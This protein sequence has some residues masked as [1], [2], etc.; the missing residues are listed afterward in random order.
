MSATGFDVFDKTL[1]TTNIWLDE[2]SATIGPDRQLA[3]KI[4]SVVLHKLR[5]RLPVFRLGLRR[6]LQH[7]ADVSELSYAKEALE[8]VRRALAPD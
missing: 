2:I 7:P 5:D 6:M 1:Q 4:L 3:W 8:K